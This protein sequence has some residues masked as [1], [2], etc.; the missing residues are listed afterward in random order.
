MR[1]EMAGL[2]P[3]RLTHCEAHVHTQWEIV[4]TVKGRGILRVGQE[5]I[6]FEPGVIVCQPPGVAHSGEGQGEYQ[7]MWFRIDGFTPP[8]A[9]EIPI[10]H[11]DAEKRF[12]VLGRMLYEASCKGEAN[13]ERIVS[14]LWEA[15]YQLLVSW[16]NRRSE[17]P[18]VAALVREMVMNISNPDFDLSRAMEKSGYC[19]DHFRRK[20][21][22]E[23]GKTPTAYLISLRIDHARRIL[24]LPEQGGYAIKQI[25]QLSGFSDPYY[26]STMFKR[27]MGVSPAFYAARA[28]KNAT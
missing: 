22:Q 1:V 18:E 11:D 19:R 12:T 23:M 15:M 6:P 24:D 3:E 8:C 2:S 21:R 4:V 5:D 25:A 9:R 20:F 7:D 13:G 10:F 16:S 26:F 17:S 27:E 14:A 28:G